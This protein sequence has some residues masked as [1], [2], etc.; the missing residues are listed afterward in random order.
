MVRAA[1]GHA[2]MT[3]ASPPLITTA[4][5]PRLKAI[6]SSKGSRAAS[7]TITRIATGSKRTP[8]ER[9]ASVV[10]MKRPGAAAAALREIVT[11]RVILEHS[12][13]KRAV[14]VASINRAALPPGIG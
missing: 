6:A 10:Q 3:K 7:S 1:S 5:R 2:G 9:E 8:S 13:A 12:R 4:M 14:P 11:L